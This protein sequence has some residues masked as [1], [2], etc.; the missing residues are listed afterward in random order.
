MRFLHLADVHLDTPFAGRTPQVRG[1]LQEASRQALRNAFDLVCRE[2]LHA[3]LIAGDLFD[4]ERLSFETEG[5]LVREFRRLEREGV[6]VVYATGNHDPGHGGLRAL[7]R[8]WPGNVTVVADRK[9]VRIPVQDREGSVAGWVTA[10]GH[11]SARETMDLARTFPRPVGETPE[12]ALLHT[13]VHGALAEGEHHRYA[14]SEVRH[15]ERAGFHYW[16][17]G[18]VH[19]RQELSEVP[20]I[21]YPGSLQGRTPAESGAR[22]GLVV[23]LTRPDHPHVT[24]HPF[25]PVRWETLVADSLLE[26]GTMEGLV[27]RVVGRWE[28]ERARDPH[29][30]ADAW[31]V[32]V[33]LQGPS[34][35]WRELSR[36]DDRAAL[37]DALAE[38]LGALDVEVRA[39]AVHAPMVVE[40]HVGR[41]DVLGEVLRLVRAVRDGD[42]E[43][44]LPVAELAAAELYPDLD[45]EAWIRELLEGV[46]PELVAQLL[47]ASALQATAAATMNARERQ[48]EAPADVEVA[49]AGVVASEAEAA[50]EEKAVA[51][52]GASSSGEGAV[53]EEVATEGAA[54][55]AT[56]EAQASLPLGSD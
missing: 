3:V 25:A 29:G 15:L 40:D 19:R 13:Q 12:V 45:P 35:L 2:K 51:S 33:V 4:R 30:G 52:E 10:A 21:H 54:P 27:E 39:G 26:A 20:A 32:R 38:R 31:L 22:G 8:P 6:P 41:V 36:E 55:N 37:E 16:A 18:H 1:R 42:V 46:E 7:G 48:V 5:F 9:P 50:S 53:E 34:P 23:D 14:P 44:D 47:D 43:L 24:F 11:A 49:A 56:R 28:T 17:L